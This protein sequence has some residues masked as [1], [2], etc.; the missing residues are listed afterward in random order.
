MQSEISTKKFAYIIFFSYLCSLDFYLCLPR[1]KKR[2]YIVLLLLCAFAFAMT[3]CRSVHE[4]RATVAQADSLLQAD[5]VFDDAEALHQAVHALSPWRVLMPTSYAKA[6]FFYGRLLRI[7]RSYSEAMP[8]LLYARAARTNDH[9]LLGRVYSNIAYICRMESNYS[10][11]CTMYECSAQA[12]L[13]AGDSMRYRI[14]LTNMAYALAEQSDTAGVRAL[15]EPVIQSVTDSLLLAMCYETYAEAYMR[16]G[17]YARGLQY[18][19]MVEGEQ[20]AAPS[21]MMIKGQCYSYLVQYDSA[22]YYARQVLQATDHLFLRANAL[23]ILTQQDSTAQL[24]DVRAAAA[25]R[26][27]V[28]RVIANDQGDLSHAVGQLEQDMNTPPRRWGLL[29]AGVLCLIVALLAWWYNI[30]RQHQRSM[31]EI[32]HEKQRAQAFI[33]ER[34]KQNAQLQQQFDDRRV[35]IEQEVSKN[36]E[37]LLRADDWQQTLCWKDYEQFCAVVNRQFFMLAD[38]LKAKGDLKDKEL[39]LCVLVMMDCFDSKQLAALLH[40]GQSG[41]RNFKQHTANKL[42]TNSRELKQQMIRL[43]TGE[44]N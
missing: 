21:L 4:A 16:A 19:N 14:G 31:A 30:R 29:L 15:L 27:A 1:M 24:E 9:E 11:A 34:Q 37:T 20:E 25:E 13:Q 5:Q 12:F 8:Y 26:A 33:H 10:L 41:I 35:K 23:Y 40:Y 18:A 2:L 3:S 36:V 42:G 6:C 39:R 17:D 44:L 43:M 38:K 28:L 22:T 32:A 7:N